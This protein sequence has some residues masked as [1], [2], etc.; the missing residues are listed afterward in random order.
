MKKEGLL[1]FGAGGVVVNTP[2]F[3]QPEKAKLALSSSTGD[4]EILIAT[5]QP[6]TS[7]HNRFKLP[8]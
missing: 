6:Q 1:G 2:L 8:S 3:L 5:L 4:A 7:E